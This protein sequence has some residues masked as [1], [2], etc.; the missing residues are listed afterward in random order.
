MLRSPTVGCAAVLAGWGAYM[1]DTVLKKWLAE[2]LLADMVLGRIWWSTALGR[3]EGDLANAFVVS[4]YHFDELRRHPGG[5]EG[6][7][8]HRLWPHSVM[9]WEGPHQR[10]RFQVSFM[11]YARDPRGYPSDSRDPRRREN[12]LDVMLRSGVAWKHI[13]RVRAGSRA[14]RP[15]HLVFDPPGKTQRLPDIQ[16]IRV[17]IRRHG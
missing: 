16:V 11:T 7:P 15:P 2:S 1:T 13:T 9:A 3:P 6:T 14:V 5:V 17:P 4:C 10:G 8:E 12:Y